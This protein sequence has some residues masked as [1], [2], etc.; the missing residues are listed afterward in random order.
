MLPG[1]D[2]PNLLFIINAASG[3]NDTDWDGMISSHFSYKPINAIVY[4]LPEKC[5]LQ[6]LKKKIAEVNPEKVIAVGG[7]GTVKL[8]AE[9]LIETGIPLGIFP[10][11][12]ANGMAKELDIPVDPIKAFD[13][14]EHGTI[15]KIHLV[16]VNDEICI[17]LSDI[18]FNAFVVKKFEEENI[19]GMWGYI[20]SAWGVLWQY[21]RIEVQIRSDEGY[22]KRDAAMVVIANG[23][24]YGNGVVINPLG[25]LQDHL[26]EVVIIRKI[27][28]SE[29]FKM[30]FLSN[31]LNEKKTELLQTSSLVLSS[32]RYVHFQVDGEYLGKT[33]KLVAEIIPEAI[34]VLVPAR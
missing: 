19:R 34:S 26:F 31:R 6:E 8:V 30:R 29:I 12:S 1:N 23:T 32:K 28:F 20:K 18:G 16:K 17:H 13:V 22:I 5:D 33:K 7:D 15:K 24:R 10:A 3:N 27:S 11:G 21:N 2:V 4:F 9:A 25:T 14:I